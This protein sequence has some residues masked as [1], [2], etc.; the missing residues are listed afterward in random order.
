MKAFLLVGLTVVEGICV[1]VAN[2]VGG[3]L[4]TLMPATAYSLLQVQ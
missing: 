4:A 2:V 1:V 3:G